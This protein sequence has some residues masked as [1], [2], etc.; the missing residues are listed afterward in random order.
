MLGLKHMEHLMNKI[1][2]MTSL[3]TSIIRNG[4]VESKELLV[5]L[6]FVMVMMD[7]SIMFKLLLALTSKDNSPYQELEIKSS[8]RELNIH[9]EEPMSNL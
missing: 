2:M 9:A 1:S 8:G 6:S 3:L 7:M 5:R 4:V